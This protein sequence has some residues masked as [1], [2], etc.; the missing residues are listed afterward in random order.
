[1]KRIEN[2]TY[3]RDPAITGIEACM[4]TRSRHVF[5][6]HFHDTIYSFTL[7]ECGAS[8]CLGETHSESLI[9][10]GNIGLINPGMVHSCVPDKGIPISYKMIYVDIER[11]QDTVSDIFK[12]DGTVLE[13]DMLIV[14]DDNLSSLFNRT[15]DLIKNNTGRLETDST[16]TELA[17]HMVF[18]YGK[19]KK[20][21]GPPVNEHRAIRI[22]MEYLSENLDQKISLEDVAKEAGLSRY[23]FLRVFKT[24]TGLSPHIFR[25][26]R[27]IAKAKHLLKK[28]IPFSHVALETG[29]SDQS[30]FTNKFRE[31][32]GATP[33]QYLVA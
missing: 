14:K 6:N 21:A 20:G 7:M 4:V 26:Q 23:H 18:R 5:P 8:Y 3:W 11:M 28:G 25:T 2:V 29:F 19:L 24:H 30:H 33:K 15:F 13:F 22:A 10:S 17:W 16:F 32:T 1:M 31:Y 12:K 9:T 27:R